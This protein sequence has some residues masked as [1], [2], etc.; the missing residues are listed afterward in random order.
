MSA[1][2]PNPSGHGAA[3]GCA[4]LPGQAGPAEPIAG[5][6]PAGAPGQAGHAEPIAGAGPARAPGQAVRAG[7]TAAA[8]VGVPVDPPDLAVGEAVGRALAEDLLPLGDLT[9]ALV[10]GDRLTAV[11]VV[12]RRPGVLAGSACAKRTCADVDPSL[13]VRWVVPDGSAVGPGTVV[14][15]VEG[16]LRSV[17]TAE[18]TMLNFLCHLSGVATLTRR[19]VDVVQAANPATRVLDTRKTTPGLRALEKAAVRAGGGHNH[20]AS[21]SDAVLVKDNHLDGVSIAEAV[22][23]ARAAWPGRMV[24][25]ECDRIE[26][27]AEALSAGA[28]MVLLDNMDPDQV[29]QCVAL[30]R[31]AGSGGAPPLGLARPLVEVSGGVDLESAPLFAAAGADFVSVGALTH[32]AP[33]LDL[34]LDLQRE[35]GHRAGS[36]PQAGTGPQAG[37]GDRAGARPQAGQDRPQG[38]SGAPGGGARSGER[39]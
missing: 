31:S 4:G 27:V 2:P 9:A 3:V 24:E 29:H 13:A 39:S 30:V 25:V 10:A 18:R 14:A 1:T 19:F 8:F 36:D 26:Q 28:T 38:P 6:G 22:S 5:A 21:L 16:S 17:L 23:R 11:A 15:T 33:A 37:A 35:L 20:R 34:G 12:A 32:S 7:S